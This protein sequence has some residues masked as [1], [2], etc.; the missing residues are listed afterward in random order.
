MQTRLGIRIETVDGNLVGNTSHRGNSLP[1]KSVAFLGPAEADQGARTFRVKRECFP[2][3]PVSGSRENRR[4][5]LGEIDRLGIIAAAVAD[6]AQG[7]EKLRAQ[8]RTQTSIVIELCRRDTHKHVRRGPL[9]ARQI[10][11]G[12]LEQTEQEV[13]CC[14][15]PLGLLA[16]DLGLP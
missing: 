13:A 16:R 10:L 11:L 6:C 7:A 3:L 15:G 12:R 5:F 2:R 9:V 4:A 14:L 8:R 1:E